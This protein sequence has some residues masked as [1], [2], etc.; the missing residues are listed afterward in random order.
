MR[1][2]GRFTKPKVQEVHAAREAQGMLGHPTGRDFLGMVCGG[3]ISDCPMTVTAVQNAHQIFCPDLAGIRGR[4]MLRCAETAG[5]F[6]SDTRLSHW[7]LI[8]CLS[9]ECH[10]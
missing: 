2:H 10:S 7:Q 9:M 6:L 4:T 1:K 5:G 8:S 3:M